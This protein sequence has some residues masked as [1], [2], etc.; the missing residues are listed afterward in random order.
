MLEIDGNDE[1]KFVK[2]LSEVFVKLEAGVVGCVELLK[3]WLEEFPFDSF[4]A[5]ASAAPNQFPNILKNAIRGKRCDLV[6]K[7]KEKC[8]NGEIPDLEVF[9]QRFPN[10]LLGAENVEGFEWLIGQGEKIS[11][12]FDVDS[13]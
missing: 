7:L 5:I 1:R 8:N 13:S 6:L 3:R 4:F 10:L 11:S 2:H 12:L 9:K